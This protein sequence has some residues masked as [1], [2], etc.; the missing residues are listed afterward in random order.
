[1]NKIVAA[2][3]LAVASIPAAPAIAQDAAPA[4][5]VAAT[6]AEELPCELHVWPT[7][8]YLGFNSGLLSGFG[9]I[10]A[11]ADIAAHDGRVK[12]VKD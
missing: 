4:D 10:G 1:M 3:A 12:T 7:Q 8:N 5:A 11:V 9:L 2:A 6:T